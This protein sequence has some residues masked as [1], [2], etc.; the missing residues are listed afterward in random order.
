MNEETLAMLEQAAEAVSTEERR[1]SPMQIAAL[2]IEDATH[3]LAEQ[4]NGN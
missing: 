1:G 3:G 2:L 4:L